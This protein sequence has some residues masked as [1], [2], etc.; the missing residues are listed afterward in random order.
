M[1]MSVTKHFQDEWL[2]A[3]E[4]SPWVTR[5][6]DDIKKAKGKVCRKSFELSNMG[7]GA[8]TSHQTK[9]EK[10]KCLIKNLSAFL[11]MPK[12]KSPADNRQDSV[13]NKSTDV[14]GETN[15]KN[16]QQANLQVAANNS[17]KLKAEFTWT[18]NR[19]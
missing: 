6:L 10:H 2:E 15:E 17:E 16:K 11:V 14:S 19:I 5:V 4:F 1:I 13:S 3:D 7:R 9:S 8:L 12:P 18:L